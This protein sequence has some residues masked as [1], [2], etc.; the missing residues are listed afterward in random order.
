MIRWCCSLILL[1]FLLF[2]GATPAEVI[3]LKS[4]DRIAADI[5]E[6][7]D[8]V[9]VVDIAGVTL[10]IPL[11]Q[12][13]EI[14]GEKEEPT[15]TPTPIPSQGFSV[16][17]QPEGD[18]SAI[19]PSFEPDFETAASDAEVDSATFPELPMLPV[20]L[21]PGRTFRVTG[22]AVRFRDG[23]GLDY[24]VLD[25]LIRGTLLV[26]IDEVDRWAHARTFDGLEGWI[27]TKY[28]EPLDNIPVVVTVDRLNLRDGPRTDHRSIQRLRRGDV[29]ILLNEQG[30]WWR[31]QSSRMKVGWC[32]AEYLVKV[33]S[34]DIVRPSLVPGGS[35][36]V[37]ISR[38]AADFGP[39]TE[40]TLSTIEDRFV[41]RGLTK[42]VAF[43]RDRR[44]LGD[45][46]APWAGRDLLRTEMVPD[47]AAM[48]RAGFDRSIAQKYEGATLLLVRGRKSGQTWSYTFE[49]PGD[50]AFDYALVVQEGP[51]RGLVVQP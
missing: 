1:S 27:H 24:E 10:K 13:A 3:H 37:Q 9:L 29:L 30:E 20:V 49:G 35:G 21:P 50:S 42:V 26:R 28:L 34:L 46:D 11:D 16:E 39:G 40:V 22:S 8:E 45:Q 44:F 43:H 23:P 18:A 5:V 4:G 47:K 12:I 17:P 15:P 41:V 32:S 36:E 2:P 51:E 33:D 19:M 6:R 7:T 48:L 31:V 38:A 14:E 25:A